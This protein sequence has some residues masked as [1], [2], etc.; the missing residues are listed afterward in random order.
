MNKQRRNELIKASA[1]ISQAQD[2]IRSVK[3]EEQVAYDMLH[4][5]FQLGKQGQ[6]MVMCIDT[7]EDACSLCDALKSTLD[8]I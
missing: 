6:Q 7:L 4:Q 1:L 2:I 8:T 5:N 3:S